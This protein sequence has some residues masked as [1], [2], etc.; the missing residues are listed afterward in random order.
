MPIDGAPSRYS[1]SCVGEGVHT[2]TSTEDSGRAL[3]RALVWSALETVHDPELDEPVAELGF[4][5]EIVVRE[6]MP[7]PYGV[8]LVRL[9]LPTRFCASASATVMV[10]DVADAVRAVP[11][12]LEA[13]IRLEDHVAADEINR[14]VGSPSRPGSA[15]AARDDELAEL[16]RAVEERAHLACLA[17]ACERLL[18]E[19]WTVDRLAEARVGDLPEDAGARLLRR[20]DVLGLS[21]DPGALLL[22]D[23]GDASSEHH[24][25][26]TLQRA[27]AVRTGHEHNAALC[28]TLQTRRD[29][30]RR[31]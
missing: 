10:A 16:R 24:H 7:G 8:V 28:R 2:S 6:L 1:R 11:E 14:R 13:E 20:R 23:A 3:I 21:P 15:S 19:G 18:A 26:R 9:R 31:T 12:I 27:R 5:T 22:V 4:V 30:V 17:R 29:A 25:I